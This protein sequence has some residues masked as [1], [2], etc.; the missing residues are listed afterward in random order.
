MLFSLEIHNNIKRDV[1]GILNFQLMLDENAEGQGNFSG[2]MYHSCTACLVRREKRDDNTTESTTISRSRR[3]ISL[4]KNLDEICQA[5]FF[6]RS[7][8][9]TKFEIGSRTTRVSCYVKIISFNVS[10]LS[11]FH[12]II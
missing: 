10:E 2:Y 6:N 5:D 8:D 11:L 3:Q 12:I 7:I 4:F 9:L 1:A